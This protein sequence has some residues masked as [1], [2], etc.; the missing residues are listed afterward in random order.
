[1]Q[2]ANFLFLKISL[3]SNVP[4]SGSRDGDEVSVVVNRSRGENNLVD[5]TGGSG[6]SQVC[7]RLLGF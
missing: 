2:R 7:P 5:L 3:T 4:I 6:S 1:M